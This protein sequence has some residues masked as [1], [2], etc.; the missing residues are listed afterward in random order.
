MPKDT[1]LMVNDMHNTQIHSYKTEEEK[2][3]ILCVLYVG[4]AKKA[5]ITLSQY[6]IDI[7]Y[8]C[9]HYSLIIYAISLFWYKLA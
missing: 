3:N 7:I 4:K 8:I 5:D 6:K 2:E 9:R 1:D